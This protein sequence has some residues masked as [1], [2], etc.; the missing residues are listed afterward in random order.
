MGKLVK[1]VDGKWGCW[2]VLDLESG[3]SVYIGVSR[4]GVVVR[5]SK[6]AL[7]GVKLYNESDIQKLTDTAV[8]LH[9]EITQF[10][11][12]PAMTNP[13]LKLFTQIA[14]DSDSAVEIGARIGKALRSCWEK[15]S[16]KIE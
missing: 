5:K 15:D 6:S 12:P 1:F 2:S 14:L 4:S 16:K 7:F 3:E 8:T 9:E 13:M 11:T 10:T